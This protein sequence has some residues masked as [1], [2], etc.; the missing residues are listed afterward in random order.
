MMSSCRRQRS[1][2]ASYFIR[3]ARRLISVSLGGKEI[4]KIIRGFFCRIDLFEMDN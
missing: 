2:A 4:F 3:T 1:A